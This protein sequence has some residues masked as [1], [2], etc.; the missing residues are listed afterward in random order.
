LH[1]LSS[2][3]SSS[4]QVSFKTTADSQINITS[5]FNGTLDE[6]LPYEFFC[7]LLIELTGFIACLSS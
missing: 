1:R 3:F 6:S 2:S 4:A 7:R 5:R